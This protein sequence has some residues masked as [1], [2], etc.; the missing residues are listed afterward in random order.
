MGVSI[1]SHNTVSMYVFIYAVLYYSKSLHVCM[2]ACMY[3]L[4]ISM[5]DTLS[6]YVCI[7]L[8]V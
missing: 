5:Y 1:F 7:V 3:V 4:Y 2:Y 6:R 8:Y